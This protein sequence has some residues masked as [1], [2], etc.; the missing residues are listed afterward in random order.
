V[1]LAELD[2][3][4]YDDERRR[5]GA[6]PRRAARSLAGVEQAL[7]QALEQAPE[8]LPA[9]ALLGRYFAAVGDPAAAVAALTPVA[10]A[11]RTSAADDLALAASLIPGG[12]RARAR[13]LVRRAAAKGAHRD[14][15]LS[16]A[17]DVDPALAAELGD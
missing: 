14:D 6:D 4:A 2:L 1:R 16:V 10:A 11:D 5:H 15:L 7:R 8:S 3:A 12:D 9:R 17:R 13:E